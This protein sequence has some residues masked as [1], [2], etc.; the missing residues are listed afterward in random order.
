MKTVLD[1]KNEFKAKKKTMIKIIYFIA[2]RKLIWRKQKILTRPKI[3][4]I[5]QVKRKA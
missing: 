2:K 4:N 1:S 5:D 3:I